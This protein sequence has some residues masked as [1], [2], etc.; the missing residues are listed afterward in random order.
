MELTAK[1]P[2]N[3][4]YQPVKLIK[5]FE[6]RAD[7]ERTFM[8]LKKAVG[9]EPIAPDTRFIPGS[10][11]DK[12]AYNPSEPT[13]CEFLIEV[14]MYN[15]GVKNFTDT[16]GGICENLEN[17]AAVGIDS[18]K[19]AC[20]IIIDGIRPF[21][22]TFSKQRSFF[23]AFF[24]ED[25]IKERFGVSD[26]K[27]CKLNNEDEEDEFAHCFMQQVNFTD[28]P[29]SILNLIFCVKQKNKRKLNTHLWFFGGFCEFIQP[30][31]VMLIDVGTMPL[32]GSLFY[33]YEAMATQK[34]LAGCCGEICP[35]DP[36]IWKLV[37]PAQVVEYKFSHIFDK[38]LESV[39]GYITVLPG[40]FSAY[41][42]EA[43]QGDPLWKD[44][45]KS[46]CHP[47]LMNAFNSNIYLAEDRVLCLALISKKNSSY[48]I[49]YVKNSVAETDVPDNIST[50]MSQRRRWINGS[51]FSLIDSI[52][53]CS[54]IYESKHNCCRKIIFSM[55][56]FYYVINILFSWVMVGSFYLAFL[57]IVKQTFSYDSTGF[58]F[59][60]FLVLIYFVMLILIFVMALGVKPNR[61]DTFFKIVAMVFG[62]YMFAT[63]I[64][65]LIY[66]FQAKFPIWVI[67]VIVGTGACFG[68]GILAHCATMTILKGLFHYLFLTPTYVN[69]FLIYS[70]CNINDCTWGNRPD[71]LS[72][73]EKKRI[74]EF[75]EFRTRW[76]IV[77]VL[78]NTGYVAMIQSIVNT[79]SGDYYIY[80]LA[81]LGISIV[82]LRF[83]G[84]IMYLFHE[85]C[86]KKKIV[87]R[88]RR[89]VNP[90]DRRPIPT[91]K[92]LDSA[93]SLRKSSSF[94]PDKIIQLGDKNGIVTLF[95][96][97]DQKNEPEVDIVRRTSRKSVGQ[98]LK[99]DNLVVEDVKDLNDSTFKIR[100]RRFKKGITL[101]KLSVITG[102]TLKELR[103]IE[104]G[105]KE[106]DTGEAEKILDAIDND[107]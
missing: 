105:K 46:I 15:E 53:K 18:S 28:N 76:L 97:I 104:D 12:L 11:L 39:L 63:I 101:R 72:A 20:I 19:I 102:M 68:L 50:L 78:C 52:R 81:F 89:R 87:Q 16:L 58:N 9:I 55:Q 56:M 77:W 103:D 1:D 96:D 67:Y 22:G 42:W 13:K 71:L 35:M 62:V 6:T 60:N 41:R 31:Y 43:L 54:K 4:Q 38:A 36:N 32:P 14:S 59:G 8:S 25:M 27:N 65:T 30:K 2:V 93:K 100:E 44:Y 48:I 107:T 91:L 33:L 90:D 74:E 83:C 80:G 95:T 49:R 45:F 10:I 61:V 99:V 34:N 3:I 37:V 94:R 26:I 23:S 86:C 21:Y 88:R 17:F 24:I 73:E 29:K 57:V 51:W 69:I 47:E 106:L 66:I 7:E 92:K 70:I 84:S 98:N 5:Q 64:C 85:S 40:A 75:E 79:S 82:L